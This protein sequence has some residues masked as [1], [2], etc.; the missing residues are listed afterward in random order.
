[1]LKLGPRKGDAAPMAM[2]E[3]LPGEDEE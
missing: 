1:I 3:L 2:I